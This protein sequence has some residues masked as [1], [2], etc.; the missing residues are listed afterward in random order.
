MSKYTFLALLVACFMMVFLT[1][2]K[3][4]TFYN[5]LVTKDESKYLEDIQ[6][7]IDSQD[8]S[9]GILRDKNSKTIILFENIIP[10]EGTDGLSYPQNHTLTVENNGY[11]DYDKS[12]SIKKIIKSEFTEL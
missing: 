6:K 5:S 11:F 12:D 8:I 2:G 9:S 3:V 10:G 1:Y 4:F 7:S